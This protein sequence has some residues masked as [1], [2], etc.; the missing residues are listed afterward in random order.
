MLKLTHELITLYPERVDLVDFYERALLNHI[1]GAQNPADGHGHVTYFTPL[2]PGGRRGVGPAW[3]GGTWS[4]DYN[5]FWCCQGT[6]IEVNTSLANSI[7]FYNDT[8]LIVNMFFPSVLNWTQ[9]GIT[10]TQATTYPVSDTTTLTVTGTVSGTWTMRIRIP[11][12]TSGATVSVNGVA[13]DIATTP[14]SYAVLTRSWSSG[15]TVTV[16]L[17]MRVTM[18]AAN[19]NTNVSAAVYGPVVLAGNYGNTSLSSPPS[20]NVASVA[21]TSSGSLAFSATAN[22]STVSLLPFYDAQNMN[23]T[24]YWNAPGQ[25]GGP[26]PPTAPPTT[27]TPTATASA[28]PTVSPTVSP[29]ATSSP[30]GSGQA[31]AVYRITGS[32]SG[33]FQAEVTV[34][35]GAAPIKG[36]TVSWSFPNG[37]TVNQLWNGTYTQS[38]ANVSVSNVSYN[39][40]LAAGASTTFGFLGTSTGTN[41]P[42]TNLTCTTT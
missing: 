8:T 14:D 40:A 42:P 6:G 9:R 16:R 4:T 32:W 26:T 19:D 5:S 33:G 3:G 21:R 13:Q 15:D 12:W 28:T 23:Y 7:Y 10:V 34:T 29:T 35:A 31:T 41:N 2:N 39:G 1:I 24:V 25:V 11:R 22:G 36:W 17:P 37:Q 20:L 27:A 38:G 30:P 18:W